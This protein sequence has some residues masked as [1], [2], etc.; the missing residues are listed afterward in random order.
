MSED[1]LDLEQQNGDITPVLVTDLRNALEKEIFQLLLFRC[2]NL[3]CEFEFL[4]YR[5]QES[6][7]VYCPKC[8]GVV[9]RKTDTIICAI[10]I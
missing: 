7:I 9:V 4:V 10:L 2:A 1:L 3:A 5:D 6:S 8:K